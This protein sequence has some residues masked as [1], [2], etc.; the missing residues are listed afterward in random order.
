LKTN[1]HVARILAVATAAGVMA[2]PVTGAASAIASGG[3]ATSAMSK[4]CKKGYKY[5]TKKGKCVKKK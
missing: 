3:D 5:S 4:K 2:L 1:R